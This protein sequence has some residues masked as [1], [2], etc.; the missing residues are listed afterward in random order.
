MHL[1]ASCVVSTLLFISCVTIHP[2][3]HS[4][5]PLPPC[6]IVFFVSIM[7]SS[8]FSCFAILFLPS[9][10]SV[11]RFSLLPP[12]PLTHPLTPTPGVL[13][14]NEVYFCL[15]STSKKKKKKNKRETR[16]ALPPSPPNT[17]N[18]LSDNPDPRPPPPPTSPRASSGS[19]DHKGEERGRGCLGNGV[20]KEL[21]AIYILFFKAVY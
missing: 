21:V 16:A 15:P 19:V 13:F 6:W 8:C 5:P 20:W 11:V 7:F 2:P 12:P 10:L 3:P 14:L 4:S 1:E 18:H 17:S 9:R